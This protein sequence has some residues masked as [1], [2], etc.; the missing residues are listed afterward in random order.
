MLDEREYRVLRINPQSS[1][2]VL[3]RVDATSNQCSFMRPLTSVCLLPSSTRDASVECDEPTDKCMCE[4]TPAPV[5]PDVSDGS[6][7]C[8][9]PYVCAASTQCDFGANSYAAFECSGFDSV[10]RLVQRFEEAKLSAYA[11][12]KEICNQVNAVNDLKAQ[13]SKLQQ[14]IAT[15]NDENDAL[16][17]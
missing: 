5:L 3:R 16:L 7:Q 15:L 8:N 10:D 14:R 4:V 6:T 13:V 2:V 11:A 17:K 9:L 12:F 1:T